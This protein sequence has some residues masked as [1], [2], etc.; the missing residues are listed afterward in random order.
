VKRVGSN[1][2][3][4]ALQ[5]IVSGLVEEM[6]WTGAAIWVRK[7]GGRSFAGHH[8]EVSKPGHADAQW[9]LRV[10]GRHLGV[11]VA[12]GPSSEDQR[13]LTGMLAGRCAHSLA[14]T[15]RSV[16]QRS[17]LGGL[18]HELRTPLQS[19]V[20]Y[21]DLLASGAL[22]A[23][24]EKQADADVELAPL[25]RQ[26]IDAVAGSAVPPIESECETALR[27]RTDP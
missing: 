27:V 4:T 14:D 1:T 18:G 24:D 15:R 16:A 19:M 8:G 26:E 22:G 2:D 23:L 10:Q 12:T 20:G 7:E 11:L 21:A 5:T 6:G 9:P 17:L 13:A 3:E 25:L